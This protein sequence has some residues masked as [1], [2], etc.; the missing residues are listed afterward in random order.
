MNED[1]ESLFSE[2]IAKDADMLQTKHDQVASKL[3][4]ADEYEQLNLYGD[5]KN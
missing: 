1:E 2:L 5:G 4:Q 3:K